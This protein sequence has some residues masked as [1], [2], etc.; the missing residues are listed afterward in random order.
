MKKLL[1]LITFL[2]I[3]NQPALANPEILPSAVNSR[4]FSTQNATPLYSLERS[5]YNNQSIYKLEYKNKQEHK[6]SL[7]DTPIEKQT[8]KENIFKGLRIIW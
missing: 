2:Q 3:L 6:Q 4:I 7:Q 1:I 8:E 5:N